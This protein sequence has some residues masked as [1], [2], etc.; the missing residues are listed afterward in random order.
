MTIRQHIR[1]LGLLIAGVACVG[2]KLLENARESNYQTVASNP[3]Q[4][5]DAAAKEHSKAL[6]IVCRH[7]EGRPA[8]LA[9]AESHLQK[10]LVADVTYGPAHNTLGTVYMR[11][12]K[13]YL[14]AWEFEYAAKVM[15]DRYEPLYNLG[16]VYECAD[17]LDSAIVYYEQALNLSP[18]NPAV[19]GNLVRTQIKSGKSIN[20]VRPM[21]EEI[22]FLDNRPDWINWARDELGRTPVQTA[23]MSDKAK[24]KP[25]ETPKAPESLPALPPEIQPHMEEGPKLKAPTPPP[26]EPALSE[27]PFDTPAEESFP[28]PLPAPEIIPQAAESKP[29]KAR[30][31]AGPAT[32]P[33][34][35]GAFSIP[36]D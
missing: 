21:L 8:N 30:I 29:G 32:I 19:M 33:T 28:P 25:P 5:S 12:R 34:E 11:Q 31:E 36:Q 9:Q 26:P 17:K 27:L 20:D 24:D 18:R 35:S 4:D 13:Y 10:A 7:L 1:I 16:Q 6:K 14:A 23:A 2:C 15:P 22:V 3:H